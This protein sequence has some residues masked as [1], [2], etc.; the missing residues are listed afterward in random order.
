MGEQE[1]EASSMV[2]SFVTQLQV[3]SDIRDALHVL[4]TSGHVEFQKHELQF[5]FKLDGIETLKMTLQ[6]LQEEVENWKK[7]VKIARD[8]YYFLNF[9]TMREILQMQTLLPGSVRYITTGKADSKD[10]LNSTSDK[11]N[12]ETVKSTE[13]VEE[14]D[15]DQ[16]QKQKQDVEELEVD[17]GDNVDDDDFEIV[18]DDVKQIYSREEYIELL[19]M[20]FESEHV[21]FAL[22]R[23]STAQQASSFIIDK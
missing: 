6:K 15:Q 3:L 14:G 18:E 5:P 21:V 10:L 1:M 4:Y 16:E 8:E 20:V 13:H 23:Y 17:D 11:N 19:N 9:F 22:K 7:T 12:E 2:E